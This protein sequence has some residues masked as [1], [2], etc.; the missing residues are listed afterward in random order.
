MDVM[1]ALHPP[2]LDQC[3]RATDAYFPSDGHICSC[4]H[5]GIGSHGGFGEDILGGNHGPLGDL[6]NPNSQNSVWDPK[7]PKFSVEA[8]DWY[9]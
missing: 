4:A 3:Q 7:S 6:W 1:I 2:S 5:V 9:K 8:Q